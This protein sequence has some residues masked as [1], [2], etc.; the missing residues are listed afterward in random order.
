MIHEVLK[1][2]KTMNQVIATSTIEPT[3]NTPSL[4]NIPNLPITEW[5]LIAC[6]FGFL[7]RGIWLHFSKE[8]AADRKMLDTLVNHI[9]EQNNK[10]INEKMEDN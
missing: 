3:K 10:L 9:Q 6:L 1:V 4:D 2:Q 5:S 7:V 8:L